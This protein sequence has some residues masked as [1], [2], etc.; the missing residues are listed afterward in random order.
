LTSRAASLV[1]TAKKA[2]ILE[3]RGLLAIVRVVLVR[4]RTDNASY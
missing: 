3:E 2:P 4:T 1:D